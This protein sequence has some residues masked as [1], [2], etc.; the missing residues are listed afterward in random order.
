MNE[1]AQPDKIAFDAHLA[2]PEF[3]CGE[4]EGRWRL[5]SID[6][7][8]A[9]IAVSAA[10]RPNAPQ[11][12]GFRFLCD[13]YPSQAVTCQPWDLQASGALPGSKWP[14]GK[15]IIPSVFNPNWNSASGLYLPTDRIALRGHDTWVHQQPWRLWRP[16]VGI[17]C[18]LEILH[19]LLQSAD[20][21]GV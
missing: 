6:W 3:R 21:L 7:P 14:K 20:Y 10:A 1:I 19:D 2:A 15:L 17:I 11:E 13:G 8:Y 4:M 5:M 18:Y 12:F 16:D 9:L